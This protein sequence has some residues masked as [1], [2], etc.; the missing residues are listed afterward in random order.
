[1][2][3]EV[4]TTEVKRDPGEVRQ[5]GIMKLRSKEKARRRQRV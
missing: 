5:E 3:R 4:G 1:M 2:A